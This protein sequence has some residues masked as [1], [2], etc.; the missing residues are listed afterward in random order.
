[1]P[2]PPD[3]TGLTSSPYEK[4]GF[5]S[6]LINHSPRNDFFQSV[7]DYQTVDP[8]V[9]PNGKK[10]PDSSTF[11]EQRMYLYKSVVQLKTVR[12]IDLWGGMIWGEKATFI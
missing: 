1:M 3:H 12:V 4:P 11:G 9:G 10:K 6:S 5:S 8:F 7:C 2:P